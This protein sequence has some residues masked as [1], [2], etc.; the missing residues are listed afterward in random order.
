MPGQ[1]GPFCSN[2]ELYQELY[3]GHCMCSSMLAVTIPGATYQ[4][5]DSADWWNS[6]L[7]H[8]SQLFLLHFPNPSLPG[9]LFSSGQAG[10]AVSPLPAMARLVQVANRLTKKYR[11]KTQVLKVQLLQQLPMR[12]DCLGSAWWA[13]GFPGR[14]VCCLFSIVW[15]RPFC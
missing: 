6:F 13:V 10:R 15:I 4:V 12:V 1:Q 5:S 7:P 14:R 3:L 8:P 2:W 11:V 9:V